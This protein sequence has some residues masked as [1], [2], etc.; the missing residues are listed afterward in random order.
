MDGYDIIEK[1]KMTLTVNDQLPVSLDVAPE[2]L[3]ERLRP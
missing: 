2:A 1:L 3:P